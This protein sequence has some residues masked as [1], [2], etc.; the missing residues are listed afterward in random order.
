MRKITWIIAMMVCVSVFLV[1]CGEKDVADVVQDV[2]RVVN[3]LE[4]YEGAGTMTLHA[5]EKQQ[6]YDVEVWYQNPHFYRIALHNTEKDI[7]QIVLRNDEGVFV[8]TPHLKKSFRFQSDWPDN[9]GQVYLYQTLAK[10]IVADVDRQFVSEDEAYVFD[11]AANYQNSSLVRQKIWLNKDN[12]APKKV[13]IADGNGNI[14]VDVVFNNFKFDKEFEE[15]AFDM[16]R[17]MSA[18][19]M[20]SLP[21]VAEGENGELAETLVEEKDV[22][23][24]S[25][26]IYEPTYLPEG[27]HQHDIKEMQAAGNKAMALRYSGTYNFTILESQPKDRMVTAQQGKM[28]DLGYTIGVLTGDDMKTLHWTYN[29][30]EFRLSAGEM[31]EEEMI[32]VAQS[33]QGQVGK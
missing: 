16:E 26:G 31:P 12:Y 30:I 1:G 18:S 14:M 24:E 21:V 9:Q 2:D 3:D 19:A 25:F 15:D 29:G 11:V 22:E 4:S 13:E 23:A 7:T 32:N 6:A 33:V 27:V 20:T 28:I 10:S 5:G 17:N 8:L